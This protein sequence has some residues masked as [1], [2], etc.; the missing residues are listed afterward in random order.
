MCLGYTARILGFNPHCS[1]TCGSTGREYKK[2]Q[3]QL[4]TGVFSE[5]ERLNGTE[6]H[7]LLLQMRKL[8]PK[9]EKLLA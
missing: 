3:S 1:F 2:F 4:C 5:T 6:G 7:H 9:K 8:G